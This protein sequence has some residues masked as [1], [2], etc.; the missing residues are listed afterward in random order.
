MILWT[1][2]Q[3]LQASQDTAQL[4]DI[5]TLKDIE[6]TG[7]RHPLPIPEPTEDDLESEIQTMEE[8]SSIA[9]DPN[10]VHLHQEASIPTTP[11]SCHTA[12]N[13]STAN[14]DTPC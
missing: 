2:I 4:P 8:N 9:K 1:C 10:I 3:Q 7:Q 5:V 12:F 11:N 13:T 14:S 6:E